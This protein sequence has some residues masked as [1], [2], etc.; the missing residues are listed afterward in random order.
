[1]SQT[2]LLISDHS[3]DIL[4][5]QHA[6]ASS[7]LSLK[8]VGNPVEAAKII[9]HET[10]RVILCDVST[11]DRYLA[12]ETALQESVG[13][14][15]DKLNSNQIHFIGSDDL[16]QAGYLVQSPI[17][18]SFLI[19]PEK[20]IEEYGQ[21]YGRVIKG[22]LQERAFGVKNFLKPTAKSQTIKLHITT[23]KQDAVEAVRNYLIAAK[24]NNRMAT[25]VANGV[26]EIL[27]NAMFDAPTDELGKPLYTHT[28]RSA[29]I[30]LEGK[31]GVEMEV[32]YD[33]HYIAVSAI[34]H[35]GSLDKNRLL[36][37]ISKVYRDAEYKV[38][39][40][41]AGAGIGLASVF[42][43]GGSLLFSCEA[44]VRTEVILFFRR[45]DN[46]KDFKSQFKFIGTQLYF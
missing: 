15:S 31:H 11:Q 6:A 38:R 3:V 43:S 21:H 16:G 46:Y 14:F 27:M 36:S 39:N 1:M 19:R 34:D 22:T 26:D 30:K 42:Q 35:F 12:L 9:E 10:P 8:T 17:F 40:Q 32:G 33:G 20:D 4:F 13:L 45:T 2:L 25:V 29:S 44:R 7:G 41:S 28:A 5:A 18:G 23:Q 24:F 37:L